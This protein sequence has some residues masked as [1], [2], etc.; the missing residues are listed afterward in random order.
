MKN[1]GRG[2]LRIIAGHWR[3]RKLRFL[4]GKELRPTPDRVRETLFNWLQTDL[5]GSR[6]L[7]LFAGSG[8]LG[9]EAASR[10]ADNVLMVEQSIDTV[11]EIRENIELLKTD[12]IQVL[13]ENVM[14]FLADEKSTGDHLG[15]QLFDIVFMDPPYQSDLLETCCEL[16]EQRQWLAKYAKIYIEYDIH[17]GLGKMP[18]SWQSLRNKKAGQVGYC[19]YQNSNDA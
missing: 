17:L 8:V 19:L 9:V 15:G 16:L 4:D 12:K 11:T 18:G 1:Y 10:G 5:I 2:E 14:N 3:G 6:C 13:C 7:D